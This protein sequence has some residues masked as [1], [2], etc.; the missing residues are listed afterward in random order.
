MAC[1]CGSTLSLA[2]FVEEPSLDAI[3]KVWDEYHKD[4]TPVS[5][6]EA[7]RIRNNERKVITRRVTNI[8]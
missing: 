2:G 5:V 4:H 7:Q 1:E 3:V 8:L 6:A